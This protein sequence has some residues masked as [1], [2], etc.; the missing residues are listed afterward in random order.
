MLQSVYPNTK[1]I[2]NRALSAYKRKEVAKD[3]ILDALSAAVTA[4]VGVQRL[5][6]IPE[7]IE[8]DSRSLRMEIVHRPLSVL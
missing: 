8:F 7:K 4:A 5:V 1:D 2:I 6:S 3:D